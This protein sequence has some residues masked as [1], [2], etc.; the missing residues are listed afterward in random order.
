[1]IRFNKQTNKNKE[2]VNE[3]GRDGTYSKYI[4]IR[5]L[6]WFPLFYRIPLFLGI[7]IR[8]YLNTVRSAFLFHQAGEG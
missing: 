8:N 7:A 4:M 2:H 5:I 1:M 3:Q 6:T